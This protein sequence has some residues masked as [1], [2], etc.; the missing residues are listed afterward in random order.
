MAAVLDAL[1]EEIRKS[2]TPS[3]IS[4]QL[5]KLAGW[6]EARAVAAI[7]FSIEKGWTG[8]FEQVSNGKSATNFAAGPGQKF[9]PTTNQRHQ[10]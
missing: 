1:T 6:G 8:L 7:E 10:S 9:D 2:L 5:K 4:A 3:T